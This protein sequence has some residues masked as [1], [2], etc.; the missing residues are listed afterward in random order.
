MRRLMVAL[1]GA[2]CLVATAPALAQSGPQPNFQNRFGNIENRIQ[3][4]LQS[5]AI[6][7]TE[8]AP[9]RDQLRQVQQLERRYAPGGLTQTERNQLQ[10]RLQSLRQQIA[11]AERNDYARPGTSDED[12][13][14]GERGRGGGDRYGRDED[15]GRGGDDRDGYGNPG[16]DRDWDDDS[17]HDEDQ[18]R[19]SVRVGSRVPGHFGGIPRELRREF[20]E[21]LPYTYRFWEG[22][23][24]Q[25]DRRTGVILRIYEAGR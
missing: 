21:T 4:G 8:A 22:R 3:A 7:R 25:V 11:T 13:W 20:P 6:T 24:Y 14:P 15:A 9:L 12:P 23:V 2:S 5:G 17:E 16:G 18:S 1:A 19:Y 10:A